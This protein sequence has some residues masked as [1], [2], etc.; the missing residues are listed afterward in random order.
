MCKLREIALAR[1][2][3]YY[4]G[5]AGILLRAYGTAEEVWANRTDLAT[6]LADYPNRLAEDMADW[7]EAMQAAEREVRFADD[8]G[9]D[10]LT[11]QDSH[12][13]TRLLRCPDAP[14]VIYCIG[15]AD[16]NARHIVSVIGTRQITDYGRDITAQFIEDLA[17]LCPDTLIISGLAYGVDINAHRAAIEHNLPTAAVLGNGLNTIYPAHHRG[18]AKRIIEQDGALLTEFMSTTPI[19]PE[20][21]LRRNRI[22]AGM[23]DATVLVESAEKGGGLA[24]ARRA[25]NYRRTVF[26]FPGDIRSPFSAGCNNIIASGDATLLTNAEQLI[27]AMDWQTDAKLD[28]ARTEGIQRKLFPELAPPEKLIVEALKKQNDLHSDLIAAATEL[29][30]AQL[31]ASLF[32]LEMKGVIRTKPGNIYHLL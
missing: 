2:T 26:A 22:V 28:K 23:A 8:N 9:I 24:T 21:F 3:N 6:T 31:R 32:T 7:D 27:A 29:H 11:P 18:D 16:L 19:S 30:V 1:L 4:P 15:Q 17:R 12:Y 20:N 25:K 13:P 5:A 10:I 14:T